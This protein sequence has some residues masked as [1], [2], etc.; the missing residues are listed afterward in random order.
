MGDDEPAVTI[1]A[2]ALA[3][4]G[5]PDL[6]LVPDH[7]GPAVDVDADAIADA[8][9]LALESLCLRR[10]AEREAAALDRGAPADKAR[11]SEIV[12]AFR[13]YRP[14]VFEA[15]RE[16]NDAAHRLVVAAFRAARAARAGHPGA[17][18]A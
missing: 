8:E 11:V 4:T 10:R 5:R 3:P 7:A 18:G 6:R 13:A 14:F 15:D 17:V 2:S 12:Y 9:A 16:K 1:T